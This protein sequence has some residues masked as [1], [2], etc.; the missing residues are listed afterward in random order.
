MT[1]L[2]PY[3]TRTRILASASVLHLQTSAGRSLVFTN[4]EL[5]FDDLEL[6]GLARPPYIR[7]AFTQASFHLGFFRGLK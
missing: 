3:I 7:P 1:S 2:V 4:L 6:S 5:S